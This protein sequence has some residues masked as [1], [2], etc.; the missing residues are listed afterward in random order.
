M[1]GCAEGGGVVERRQFAS[2]T[3]RVSTTVAGAQVDSVL[4]RLQLHRW[5]LLPRGFGS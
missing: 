5:L 2:R 3:R 4:V 1:Q